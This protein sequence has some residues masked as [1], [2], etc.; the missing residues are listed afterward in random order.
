M[1]AT[2]TTYR[3]TGQR[4]ESNLGL[5]FY[6]ARWYD[7]AAG[8]F[9]Q[10]DTIVP[11]G[12][13]GLDRYAY[14]GNN[15]L[16]YI[17][18][19]GHG[20]ESTDC[21]PDGI[22]CEQYRIG[23]NNLSCYLWH[24]YGVTISGD[25]WTPSDMLAIYKGV[26]ATGEKFADNMPGNMTS[27]E[28]IKS[29]YPSMN[30]EMW[31]GQCAKSCWGMSIDAQNIRLYRYYTTRDG[32]ILNTQISEQLVVHELGHSFET[33]FDPSGKN[34]PHNT[35]SPGMIDN[36]NGLAGP[37]WIWQQSKEVN[38]LEIFADMF[39]GWVYNKWDFS[40]YKTE[41]QARQDFMNLN[42]PGWLN[43]IIH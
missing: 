5:Y 1:G 24:D 18:P 33:A 9:V 32:Y 31:N 36:R 39:P 19:S 43:Q 17:D 37:L 6:G 26:K 12:V 21:G 34:P 41:A 16:K 28:A 11:G 38:A 42:M 7:P 13:Q 14:V 23:C 10:P 8:R 20:R 30:F 4:L 15:P 35:L 3:F 22:Y 40:N 25:N 29:V 27:S 2:P